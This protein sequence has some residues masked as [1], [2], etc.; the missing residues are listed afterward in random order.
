MSQTGKLSAA[1]RRQLLAS[2]PSA[3]QCDEARPLASSKGAAQ[4]VLRKPSSPPKPPK[5]P[6]QDLAVAASDES[7]QRAVP[8]DEDEPRVPFAT[9]RCR[10]PA[11]ALL[12]LLHLAL[13]AVVALTQGLPEYSRS[14]HRREDETAVRIGHDDWDDTAWREE[15]KGADKGAASGS[16]AL[17]AVLVATAGACICALLVFELALHRPHAFI[18]VTALDSHCLFRRLVSSTDSCCLLSCIPADSSV[19]PGGARG[20]VLGH[21][22]CH[23]HRRAGYGRRHGRAMV[24]IWSAP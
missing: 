23:G 19:R 15:E 17:A 5:P 16:G 2:Q 21:R 24:G 12:F 3:P 8:F 9:R 10:D 11:W 1:D 18:Q 4:S 13:I 14:A 7:A 20:V 22:L 6:A